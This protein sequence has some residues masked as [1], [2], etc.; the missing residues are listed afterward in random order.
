MTMTTTNIG[1]MGKISFSTFHVY[2]HNLDLG[3]LSTIRQ[4]LEVYIEEL[5]VYTTRNGG[6]GRK[7]RL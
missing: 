1:A 7:R 4:A 6:T 5:D 2:R 3:D